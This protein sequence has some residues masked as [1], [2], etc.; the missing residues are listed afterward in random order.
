MRVRGSSRRPAQASA[1]TPPVPPPPAELLREVGKLNEERLTAL[2]EAHAGQLKLAQLGAR[3]G[4]LEEQLDDLQA[5]VTE[6]KAANATLEADNAA[7]RGQL[8]SSGGSGGSAAPAEVEALRTALAAR[9]TEL[10]EARAMLSGLSAEAAAANERITS[11][12]Q[13]QQMRDM[14][15][16]K[17]A[18][19]TQLRGQLLAH[20]PTAFDDD[21]DA[22]AGGVVHK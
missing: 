11:T 4:M 6:L 14:L 13:F 12:R 18:T 19:I 7:L 22:A 16:K 15:H 17:N 20:D 21:A 9:E 3:K 1:H 8:A 10:A 5:Q 2:R